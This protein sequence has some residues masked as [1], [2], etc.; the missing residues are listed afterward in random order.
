MFVRSRMRGFGAAG[1]MTLTTQGA[2]SSRL[3][4]PS[5]TAAET[6]SQVTVSSGD[7]AIGAPNSV[8]SVDTGDGVVQAQLDADGCVS[9]MWQAGGA[10]STG[11]SAFLAQNKTLVMVLG[12]G[13]FG[14]VLLGGRRR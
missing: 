11:F 2:P 12:I 7:C 8:V 9:Q 6:G 10:P 3:N 1:P 5:F 14:L 13:L 4:F